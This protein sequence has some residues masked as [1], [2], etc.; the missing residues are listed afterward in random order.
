MY[1]HHDGIPSNVYQLCP[2]YADLISFC[3]ERDF[4]MSLYDK[5]QTKA[6]ESLISTSRYLD[7]LLNINNPHFENMVSQIYPAE[8][9]L[10]KAISS[11]TGVLFLDLYLSIANGIGWKK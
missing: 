7:D 9:Q 4:I 5:N 8:F 3:Y 10:I 1:R 11:D 6:I 2:S